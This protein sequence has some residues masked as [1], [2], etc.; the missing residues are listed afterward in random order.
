[1]GR[2]SASLRGEPEQTCGVSL[3]KFDGKLVAI[4]HNTHWVFAACVTCTFF[5]SSN[6]GYNNSQLNISI[7]IQAICLSQYWPI[8]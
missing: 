2:A 3:S 6:N 4:S 7:I 5:C 1:M 8:M